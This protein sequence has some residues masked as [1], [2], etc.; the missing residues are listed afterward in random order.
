[1]L[2]QVTDSL[3]ARNNLTLSDLPNV[4]DTLA[5][6]NVDY[7]DLYFQLSQDENW[8]LEDSIIKEGGFHIDGGVGVRAAVPTRTGGPRRAWPDSSSTT[9]STTDSGLS[10]GTTHVTPQPAVAP[11]NAGHSCSTPP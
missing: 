4:F 2:K 7:A 6:R 11:V 9:T 1:M 3:L 8:V 10:Y 5:Q